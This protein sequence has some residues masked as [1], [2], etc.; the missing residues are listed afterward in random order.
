ETC[1]DSV[2]RAI[3]DSLSRGIGEGR[4]LDALVEM[5]TR[6][7]AAVNVAD[8]TGAIR[9]SSP[10]GWRFGA[11]HPVSAGDTI[12]IQGVARTAAGV[13]AVEVAGRVVAESDGAR[14]VPF[15]GVWV[16]GG[17]YGP[18]EVPVVVRTTDGD[19]IQRGFP[20]TVVP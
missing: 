11:P 20:V 19:E 16:A 9:I 18:F 5:A 4:D 2:T 13:V 15:E 17:T 7:G 1:G 14:E 6:I 8:D 10:N 3:G 12:R